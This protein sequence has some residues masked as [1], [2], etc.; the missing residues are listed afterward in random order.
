MHRKNILEAC[1]P[2]NVLYLQGD[3]LSTRD[4]ADIV[5]TCE[6]LLMA[7]A[8]GFHY[9]TDLQMRLRQLVQR[10]RGWGLERPAASNWDGKGLALFLS[11][12]VRQCVTAAGP[13][14]SP[15]ASH[16]VLAPTLLI[17]APPGGVFTNLHVAMGSAEEQVPGSPDTLAAYV[18]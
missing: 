1:N 12:L 15:Y 5:Y 9:S 17:C 8:R 3:K 10:V 2:A 14:P 18:A 4:L 16:R 11:S 6:R 7:H 13:S